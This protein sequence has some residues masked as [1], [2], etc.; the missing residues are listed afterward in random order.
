MLMK[1]PSQKTFTSTCTFYCEVLL[2][3]SLL[4]RLKSPPAFSAYWLPHYQHPRPLS[5][6][7]LNYVRFT[8]FLPSVV[9][10]PLILYT[11]TRVLLLKCKSVYR[12][13]NSF[14][15]PLELKLKP[16]FIMDLYD[17]VLRSYL[18]GLS[19]PPFDYY[20]LTMSNF[21]NASCGFT[22]KL[23]LHKVPCAFCGLFCN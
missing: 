3:R 17:L 14:M 9:F 10:I 23:P 22:F 18:G 11:S 15:T 19:I 1:Y 16:N 2:T 4:N 5:I 12:V 21:L 13:Y 20:F 7:C 8:I 6:S